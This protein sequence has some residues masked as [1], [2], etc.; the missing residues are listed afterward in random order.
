MAARVLKGE[1]LEQE[2]ARLEAMAEYET[3]YDAYTLISAAL[4]KPDGDLW[5]DRWQQEP[6][7]CQ[8]D[9]ASCISTIPRSCR[10]NAGRICF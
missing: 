8:R 6:W 3:E 9:A 5:Q 4:M 1:K 7:C 10:R 2:M